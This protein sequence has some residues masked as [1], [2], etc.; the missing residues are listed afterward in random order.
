MNDFLEIP[1]V[2]AVVLGGREPNYLTPLTAK[3]NAAFRNY[4]FGLDISDIRPGTYLRTFVLAPLLLKITAE[5]SRYLDIGGFDGILSRI[6]QKHTGNKPLVLDLDWEGLRKLKNTGVQPLKASAVVL[7]FVDNCMYV[8]WALDLL[9]HLD[10]PAESLKEIERVLKPGGKCLITTPVKGRYWGL[11][12][13]EM[14]A[15]HK[16]WG[17]IYPGFSEDEITGLFVEA[18]LEVSEVSG[19]F[20]EITGRIYHHIYVSGSFNLDEKTAFKVWKSTVENIE[21]GLP[22]Q[23]IEYVVIAR[24]PAKGEMPAKN[25]VSAPEYGISQDMSLTVKPPRTA[26]SDWIR[27]LTGE[28][29]EKKAIMPEKTKE[30]IDAVSA[31]I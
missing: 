11:P 10:K 8:I 14:L 16:K 1:A 6:V 9:E 23:P 21:T 31:T 3:E 28:Y 22:G 24:K 26:V 30:L 18:G 17:H 27:D 25:K 5:G 19:Y 13:S 2:K 15:L 29:R 4:I 7:P 12:E 20:C